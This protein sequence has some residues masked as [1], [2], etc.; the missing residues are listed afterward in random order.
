MSEQMNMTRPLAAVALACALACGVAFGGSSP[1]FPGAEGFGGNTRGGRGGKV[2]WV[3][4]LNRS[5]PG[6]LLA[7]LDTPGPRIIKFK[8]AG[9]IVLDRRSLCIGRPFAGKYTQLIKK[10]KRVDEIENPYSFVTID[11]SSAPSPGITISG[12]LVTGTYGDKQVIIRNLRIRDNGLVK[13][14][15]SDCIGTN[16]SHV[17]IDH[18]SLQWARDEVVNAWRESGHGITVQWC[19]I[20]PGWGP[21]GYGFCNGAG[22]DRITLHHNLFAHNHGRNPLICGNSRASWVGK[23]ANDTPIVDCRNNV[24]YNWTHNGAA[25]ITAGAHVNMV[26]NLFIPGPDSQMKHPVIKGGWRERI[27][28]I[29]LYLKGN[30]SPRRPKGDLDEWA[31][32]GHMKSGSRSAFGPWEYGHRRDA[33]FPAAPVVTH[34]AEEARALVLSQSG[35]WPR[36]PI[37]AGIIRTVRHGTG[38]A[39]VDNTLPSDFANAKPSAEARASLTGGKGSLSV[40]FQSRAADRDGKIVYHTWHF[41]DG[42]RAI[43]SNVTHTYAAAGEYVP[44]LFVTDDQGA[45]ETAS[46]RLHLGKHGLKADPI[47]PKPSPAVRSEPVKS[48]PPTVRLSAP[49]AGPPDEQ[50]WR[51]APCL[52]PFIDQAT[53][54]KKREGKVDARIL[55]DSENLYVRLICAGVSEK[56][57]KRIETFTSTRRDWR[58]TR[59]NN[60]VMLF[61][62]P[63]YGE[64]AWYRL[65]VGTGGNRYDAKGA[66]RAW[67]PSPDWRIKSK[68]AGG[69]WHLALAIPLKAM[70]AE[71]GTG[72]AWGLKLI[73]RTHKDDLSIWPP[74]GS[75]GAGRYCAPDTW[76]PIYYGKLHSP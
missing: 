38:Y 1:A 3:T 5:G 61:F 11:G 74:V 31:D 51:A 44:T 7:A 9:T 8:V 62:S 33:P 21:H 18:C 6:S 32:A 55:Y 68:A 70:G 52:A 27:T 54:R 60:G 16:S 22:T 53:W 12:N 39:S 69:K 34:S 24:T 14:D 57:V 59:S 76:D 19:I 72:H 29:A 4:N 56:A 17:L 58:E 40:Q 65:D 15:V 46:L 45:G 43:G 41:G 10:G 20:G 23:F 28:P 75:A 2:I 50:D 67:N 42:R 25:T 63:R 71:T 73:I 26:G 30:I 47:R 13:R 48:R 64:T 36:D 37:D 66:D 35:C 49:L